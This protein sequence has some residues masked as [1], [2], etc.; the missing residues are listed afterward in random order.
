MYQRIGS[1]C[2][3]CPARDG[4]NFG[5]ILLTPR[6]FL[7]QW[8]P[9]IMH[10][11][12]ANFPKPVEFSRVCPVNFAVKAR[13][14][15]SE[16]RFF[17]DYISNNS[18]RKNIRSMRCVYVFP[19]PKSVLKE[20]TPHPTI[21]KLR[22]YFPNIFTI[23]VFYEPRW[24]QKRSGH[25]IRLDQGFSKV[26]FIISGCTSDLWTNT[27]SETSRIVKIWA[28]GL[29]VT[30]KNNWRK[31]LN[32]KHGRKETKSM[33]WKPTATKYINNGKKKRAVVEL[34][35]CPPGEA[36]TGNTTQVK[37][38]E[39]ATQPVRLDFFHRKSN[40]SRERMTTSRNNGLMRRTHI[41]RCVESKP[42][43]AIDRYI[44]T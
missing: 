28:D 31:K 17:A 32:G 27:N 43:D 33:A 38:K 20:T 19:W 18:G 11:D 15:P 34:L 35:S 10:S 8:E 9:W 41:S 5:T 26:F 24:G 14:I 1:E 42:T 30:K 22:E 21:E 29:S 7:R 39:L 23:A 3:R 13:N 37:Q 40:K 6:E 12:E 36:A 44:S 2:G 25:L 16:S 4:P